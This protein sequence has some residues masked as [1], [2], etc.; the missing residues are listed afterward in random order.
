VVSHGGT[1]RTFIREVTGAPPP[2]LE[3]GALF[4]ARWA[5]DRFASVTRV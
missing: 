5:G 4:V 2:P 3:N 1:I